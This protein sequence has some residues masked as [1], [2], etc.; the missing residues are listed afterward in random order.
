[1]L[2]TQVPAAHWSVCV[3]AFPSLQ[4]GVPGFGC[5]TQASPASLQTPSLQT[6]PEAAQFRGPVGAQAPATQR[7]PTVQ[8]R[9]SV[10][11]G[12][13][14]S[15]LIAD[16]IGHLAHRVLGQVQAEELLLPAQ[17][18]ADGRLDDTG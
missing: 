4:V 16:L 14:G 7:S 6:L 12:R 17:P 8:K 9:P 18:L 15:L 1:M 3:Q 13:C 2:P 11:G 5:A 10:Q